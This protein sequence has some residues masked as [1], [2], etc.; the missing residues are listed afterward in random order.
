[1]KY[2][3]SYENILTYLFNKNKQLPEEVIRLGKHL[4]AFINNNIDKDYK[5]DYVIQHISE[6]KKHMPV[7]SIYVDPNDLGSSIRAI[8]LY[9]NQHFDVL[10]FYFLDNYELLKN[11]QE[12]IENILI[13]NKIKNDDLKIT[14]NSNSIGYSIKI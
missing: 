10:T 5:A 2:I 6:P 9:Y 7:L 14:N 4:K 11:I 1:M 12:F 8:G 3:K 13:F